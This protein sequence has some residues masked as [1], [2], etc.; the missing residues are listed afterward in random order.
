M[1]IATLYQPNATEKTYTEVNFKVAYEKL[2]ERHQKLEVRFQQ[3]MD[4]I[5]YL[6]KRV[7]HLEGENAYLR[8]QLFSERSERKKKRKNKN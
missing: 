3:A 6:E 2:F 8:K 1:T 5:D 4:R 7:K